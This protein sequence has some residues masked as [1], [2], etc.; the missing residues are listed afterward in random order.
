MVKEKIIMS[1]EKKMELLNRT[2][3]KLNQY[4]P[5]VYRATIYEKPLDDNGDLIIRDVGAYGTSMAPKDCYNLNL[6]SEIYSGRIFSQPNDLGFRIAAAGVYSWMR[7]LREYYLSTRIPYLEDGHYK[8]EMAEDGTICFSQ[9]YVIADG[10][11][12]LTLQADQD[13]VRYGLRKEKLL[14]EF[15]TGMTLT[16]AIPHAQEAFEDCEEW[17]ITKT[18]EGILLIRNRDIP[19]RHSAWWNYLDHRLDFLANELH[20]DKYTVRLIL[21]RIK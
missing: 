8:T 3:E 10:F 9:Q 12:C 11:P 2:V 21:D 15:E 20:S 1:D 5:K 18:A 16:E 14:V 19:A 4:L 13:T 6:T 7:Y 17:R